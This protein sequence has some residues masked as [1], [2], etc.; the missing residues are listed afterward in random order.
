MD[1]CI[2]CNNSFETKE[3]NKKHYIHKCDECLRTEKR[4]Y[5]RK[6]PAKTIKERSDKFRSKLRLENP[7]LHKAREMYGSARKRSLKKDMSFDLTSDF[8][9]GLCVDK[10]PIFNADLLYSN[11]LRN[12]YAPSLD[13]IDSSKGYVKG[14]VWVISYLANLMKNNATK[15]ELSI[16]ADYYKTLV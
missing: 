3:Y 9:Y 2:K 15:E 5:A 16:F 10:C 8:I 12:K 6:L 1:K 4:E 11:N 7:K 13:R 14:N